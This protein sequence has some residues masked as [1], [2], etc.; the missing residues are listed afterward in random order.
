MVK[1]GHV[2]VCVWVSVWVCI[3]SAYR[4]KV[5]N[6]PL[7]RRLFDAGQNGFGDFFVNFD[8]QFRFVFDLGLHSQQFHERFGGGSL[9]MDE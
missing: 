6:R 8:E 7:T 9:E 2:C 3:E 4:P 5:R 1:D